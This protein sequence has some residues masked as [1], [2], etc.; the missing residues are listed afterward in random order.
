M[1]PSFTQKGCHKEQI[2]NPL[3]NNIEIGGHTMKT[4]QYTHGITFFVTGEMYREIKAITDGME[5]GISEFIRKLVLDAF[6]QA[7]C[8]ARGHMEAGGGREKREDG[9]ITRKGSI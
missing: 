3:L 7:E 9:T 4:K 6:E 8:R 5:I 1:S 2:I